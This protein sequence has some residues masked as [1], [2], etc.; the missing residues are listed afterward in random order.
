[1][2]EQQ[3]GLHLKTS[4]RP[5]C[6]FP[7]VCRALAAQ[8]KED[9]SK[10]RLRRSQPE[11]RL[12]K[13]VPTRRSTWLCSTKLVGTFRVHQEN[14]VRWEKGGREILGKQQEKWVKVTEI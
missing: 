3:S 13:V 10:T 2:T 5:G 12:G 11:A 4:T 8:Q 14:N 6:C 9:S 7:G 1:M